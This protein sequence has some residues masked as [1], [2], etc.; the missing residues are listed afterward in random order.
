[1]LKFHSQKKNIPSKYHICTFLILQ[2]QT[3]H[4]IYREVY[5]YEYINFLRVFQFDEADNE[6]KQK[7]W[8]K[9]Y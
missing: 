9:R 2:I 1:M 3:R 8:K 7:Q 4:P 6:E 5:I